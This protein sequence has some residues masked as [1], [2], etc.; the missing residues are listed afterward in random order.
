[1]VKHVYASFAKILS[2]ILTTGFEILLTSPFILKFFVPVSNE[3]LLGISTVILALL[4][5]QFIVM[6]LICIMFAKF[7]V[8]KIIISDNIIK[9]KNDFIVADE[10]RILYSKITIRNIWEFCPGELIAIKNGEKVI[11]GWYTNREI[12]KMSKYIRNIKYV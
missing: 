6:E 3:F 9:T 1:M 12:K 4:C 8:N 5:F 11:L 7:G 10:T 2:L